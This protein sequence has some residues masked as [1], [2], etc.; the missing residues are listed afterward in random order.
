[1]LVFLLST[2]GSAAGT[3]IAGFLIYDRLNG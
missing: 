2:L 1:L 3:Y